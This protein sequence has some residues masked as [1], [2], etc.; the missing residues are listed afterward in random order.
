MTIQE[1]IA[2]A[3][4]DILTARI[5]RM[6]EDEVNTRIEDICIEDCVDVDEIVD[7]ALNDEGI[8]GGAL[9]NEGI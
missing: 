4:Q 1:Q 7:E 8:I 2:R 5:T 6:V 9:N 3:V